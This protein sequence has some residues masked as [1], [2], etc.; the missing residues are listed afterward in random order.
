MVN[1]VIG[2]V[3]KQGKILLVQR[4]RGDFVGLWAIPGGK[5]EECEHIDEA[6]KREMLEEIG[7]DM[8]FKG[9]LGISTEIM[10]DKNCT[11]LLY[12]CHLTMNDEDEIKNPE[13]K[14]KWFSQE[15]IINSNNIVESDKMF[16]EEFY[17]KRSKN[18][19]KLDCYRDSNGEYY[20]K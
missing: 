20:W 10:H 13:F 12:V 17:I 11:S 14:Y 5:V 7:I 9:V 16:I 19:L 18:Y 2:I 4:E 8:E 3:E 6:V 1:V 15:E